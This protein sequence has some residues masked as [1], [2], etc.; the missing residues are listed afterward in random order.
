MSRFTKPPRLLPGDTVGVIS[1]SAGLAALFPHR[2]ERGAA[3]L[4]RLGFKVVFGAC[5]RSR[6]GYL[7]GTAAERAAD[8][9]AFAADPAVRA[10]ISSIGGDHSCQILP[11]LDWELLRANPKIWMGF[12]DMMVLNVA[13]MA[14]AGLVTFNGPHLM[15]ELAD[16]PAAPAY[17][18]DSM[19]RLLTDPA[20]AGRLEP[21]PWQTDEFLDWGAQADLTRERART[22]A[23]GW[24]WIKPGAAEGHLVGG[25]LESLQ[26]LR[27][28]RFWP[29]WRGAILFL[30]TS[31][32]VPSPEKVDGILMDYQNMGVFDQIS[33]LLW[34]RSSGYDEAMHA[35]LE[36]ILLERTAAYQ[37]PIVTRMDFGHTSP[38]LTMPLGCL[39]R[40]DSAARS[41]E[42]IEG[43]VA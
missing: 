30:E 18:I 27:G 39:A 34:G 12:S 10:V 43:A 24:R 36:A 11:L 23:P 14:A 3:A 38:M 20:P 19:L 15:T 26:H 31:E 13:L 28:T 4:E 33:G 42:L 40:L 2:A 32:E 21:S 6:R 22:P 25:C 9:H 1:P 16:F 41:F 17:S 5:A 7:S 29:D 35:E 37:F 8:I